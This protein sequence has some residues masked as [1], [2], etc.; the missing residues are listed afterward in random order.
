M[1]HDEIYQI[2]L[3]PRCK[4]KDHAELYAKHVNRMYDYLKKKGLGMMIWSDMLQP[5][6]RYLTPS[7]IKK[8][9]KDIIMLDFIWYFHFDIDM[10]DHILPYGFNVIIGII[11][12]M[13]SSHYPRF[14]SR[15]AKK[16]MIGGEVSTWCRFDEYNLAKKGKI[17]DLLYSAE[18]LWSKT[19]DSDAREVYTKILQD[20]IPQIRD[21]LRGIAKPENSAIISIP[22]T[23]PKSSNKPLPQ[24]LPETLPESQ[25]KALPKALHEPLPE[26]IKSI[27]R[28]KSNIDH[29]SRYS[30]DLSRTQYLSTTSVEAKVYEKFRKLIFLHAT[31]NN[32]ERIAWKPLTIVGEYIVKYSDDTEVVIPVEYAGNICVWTRRYAQPM[33]QQYYRHQGYIA[34]YFSDSL[35]QAK[36]ETGQDITVLGYEWVNP[37]PNSEIQSIICRGNN[38]TDAKILLFGISGIR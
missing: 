16:G 2:G 32:A 17:F 25:S 37:Y 5:T 15:I 23:L 29:I 7:S 12:N 22:I 14:E 11:G 21:E 18:M 35:I 27:I 19:Y 26:A 13:Y 31:T 8:I 1:G 36:T 33:S 24:A 6:E 28:K 20:R 30:F 38:T 3:C 34:T 4:G 9:P 10:E